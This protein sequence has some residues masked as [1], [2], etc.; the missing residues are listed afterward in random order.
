MVISPAFLLGASAGIPVN[1]IRCL[2][3]HLHELLNSEAS[4]LLLCF[5]NLLTWLLPM[6]QS[7]GISGISRTIRVLG[8]HGTRV[9]C[10]WWRTCIHVRSEGGGPMYPYFA[11]PCILRIP[12]LLSQTLS[13]SRC[14]CSTLDMS[15][16][17]GNS[18]SHTCIQKLEFGDLCP[19]S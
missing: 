18:D 11:P 6:L 17:R 2:S 16:N 3:A 14:P 10:F 12:V 13:F 5:L 1:I 15:V 9:V 8:R 4:L 7:E 19:Q